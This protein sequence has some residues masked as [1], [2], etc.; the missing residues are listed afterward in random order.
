M[1]IVSARILDEDTARYNVRREGTFSSLTGV[2]NKTSGLFAAIGF[3]L[4]SNLFGYVN[5]DNPGPEPES[6]ARFLISQFPLVLMIICVILSYFLR[7][8]DEETEAKV[9][10]P[11]S[12]H[13]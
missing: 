6:A 1:D 8:P 9:V 3:A 10:D 11:G 13:D 12:G 4:V 5:G 7:F 2:L